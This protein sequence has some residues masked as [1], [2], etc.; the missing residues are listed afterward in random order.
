[1]KEMTEVQGPV[2]LPR[3]IRTA[4]LL[5]AEAV[6]GRILSME[7]RPLNQNARSQSAASQGAGTGASSK[8]TS[9]TNKGKRGQAKGARS[10]TVLEIYLC[11]GTSTAD[12]LLF[13]VWED[14]MRARIQASAKVGDTVRLS[15]VL[16]V[17]HTDK[18]RWYTTSRAPVFLKATAE[19][20]LDRIQ[21]NPA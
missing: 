9:V 1:M 6:V 3:D 17:A 15:R 4:G 7:P 18:T 10:D 2:K 21:D 16:V 13:E 8:G 5:R 12:V 19:T 11:G 14:A 20:T